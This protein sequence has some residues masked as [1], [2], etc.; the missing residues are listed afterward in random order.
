MGAI[1]TKTPGAILPI[2]Q[3]YTPD[4]NVLYN[5]EHETPLKFEEVAH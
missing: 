5:A 3:I 2:P 4:T 1:S